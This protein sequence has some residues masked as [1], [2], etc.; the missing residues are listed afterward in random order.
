MENQLTVQSSI[1]VSL[2]VRVAQMSRQ[3]VQN[4]GVNWGALGNIGR[5][6]T[7][8]PALSLA[9]GVVGIGAGALPPPLGTGRESASTA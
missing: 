4:L 1:Q 5:I 8:A 7:L 9:T 3:V 2:E 6:G